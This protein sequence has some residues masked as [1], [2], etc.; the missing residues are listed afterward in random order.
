MIATFWTQP[1][2]AGTLIVGATLILLA[3]SLP[4]YIRGDVRAVE[5][6]F[7]SIEVA[8]GNVPVLRGPR[9]GWA[10]G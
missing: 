6:Q 5:A 2:I 7:R 1:R 8:V 3:V 10:P 4:F 9:P